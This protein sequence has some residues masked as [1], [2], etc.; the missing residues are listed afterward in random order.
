[1]RKA[2]L[3]VLLLASVVM[4]AGCGNVSITGDALT[5]AQQ[6]TMDAYQAA[7]RSGATTSTQ[8]SWEQ[9]YLTENFLQWRFFVRSA[10]KDTTWG[11]KLPSE[12]STQPTGQ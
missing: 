5:A 1:M 10:V 3:V 6:S 7:Q 2:M 9:S 4:L 8:P 12:A 11:P